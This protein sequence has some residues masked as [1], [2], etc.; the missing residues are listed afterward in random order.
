[1]TAGGGAAHDGW[2]HGRAGGVQAGLRPVN[3]EHLPSR[4]GLPLL[5]MEVNHLTRLLDEY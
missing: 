2:H 5:A 1:M 3:L 4:Y